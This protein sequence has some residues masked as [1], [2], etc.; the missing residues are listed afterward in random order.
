MF[1]LL[2]NAKLFHICVYFL[3]SLK[4]GPSAGGAIKIA[5]Q[6]NDGGYWINSSN[7][8]WKA[9]TKDGHFL[10]YLPV[11]LQRDDDPRMR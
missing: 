7:I 4:A 9:K 11:S 3:L 1:F 5:N 6:S 10:D 8:V 2:T